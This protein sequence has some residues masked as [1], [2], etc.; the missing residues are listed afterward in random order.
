MLVAF[1]S[2][3]HLGRPT[4]VAVAQGGVVRVGEVTGRS[5]ALEILERVQEEGPFVV[6]LGGG[7][8]ACTASD[9]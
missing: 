7:H 1:Q 6:E 9:G 2:P 5:L 4:G 8:G 3:Q